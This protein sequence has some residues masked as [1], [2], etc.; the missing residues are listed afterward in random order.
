MLTWCVLRS[1]ISVG[2]MGDFVTIKAPVSVV[3]RVF[4]VEMS[5]YRVTSPKTGKTT[6]LARSATRAQLPAEVEAAIDVMLGLDDFAVSPERAFPPAS[7]LAASKA[8]AQTGTLCSAASVHCSGLGL[9]ALLVHPQVPRPHAKRST[10]PRLAF[11]VLR[12]CPARL[13]A[14]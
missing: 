12:T 10:T 2:A 13:A 14:C 11:V 7:T 9:I 5:L 1:H 8:R 4:G 3:E 6:Y